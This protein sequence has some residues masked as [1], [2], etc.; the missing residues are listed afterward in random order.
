MCGA[1]HETYLYQC[2]WKREMDTLQWDELQKLIHIRTYKIGILI[3]SD[4]LL[5]P[6]LNIFTWNNLQSVNKNSWHTYTYTIISYDTH[7]TNCRP[8]SQSFIFKWQH[9]TPPLYLSPPHSPPFNVGSISL[10]A[11]D[12][13]PTNIGVCDWGNIWPTTAKNLFFLLTDCRS[14]AVYK[15][16]NPI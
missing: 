7:V 10:A 8:E 16:L 4:Y 6:W 11:E 5:V 1:M 12:I 13:T 2:Q 14:S 9:Q 3:N 15:H